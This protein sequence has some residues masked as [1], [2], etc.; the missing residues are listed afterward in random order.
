MT[1]ET[2]LLDGLRW[3]LPIVLSA[4]ALLSGRSREERKAHDALLK[5]L[6]VE[7]ALSDKRMTGFQNELEKI[8]DAWMAKHR[9]HENKLSEVGKMRE[10]MVRM[11]TELEHHGKGFDKLER[12]ID[13]LFT[14]IRKPKPPH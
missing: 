14:E 7:A 9:D 12:K 2:L 5:K 4:Y 8:A 13:D 10:E 6:E 11:R 1:P 3:L